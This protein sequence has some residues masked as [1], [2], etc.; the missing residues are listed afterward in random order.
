M[1]EIYKNFLPKQISEIKALEIGS[2]DNPLLNEKEFFRTYYIDN[3]FETNS[4]N[5][6][7]KKLFK[8]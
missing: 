6:I 5:K 8:F 3:E 4:A 2:G 1:L 7:N